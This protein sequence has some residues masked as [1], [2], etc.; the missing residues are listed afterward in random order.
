M[1][2]STETT[3]THQSHQIQPPAQQWF[4]VHPID[5]LPPS[6]NR[7]TPIHRPK[8]SQH[9]KCTRGSDDG[10]FSGRGGHD[11]QRRRRRGAEQCHVQPHQSVF[12][13][14]DQHDQPGGF[15]QSIH[16]SSDFDFFD[17]HHRVLFDGRMR[18][19][20]CKLDTREN[21]VF[22]LPHSMLL[23]PFVPV[24]LLHFLC[25]FFLLLVVR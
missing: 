12:L 10:R 8:F 11:I 19:L 1:P 9:R 14:C 21:H 25:D 23:L 3:A 6:R 17:H 7:T 4:V 20:G 2:A 16:D 13:S 18:H 24:R 22:E 5:L 15:C